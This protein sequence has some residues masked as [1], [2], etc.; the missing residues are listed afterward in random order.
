MLDKIIS[1]LLLST[2]VTGSPNSFC[3]ECKAV[4][5]AFDGEDPSTI[6]DEIC[7]LIGWETLC[8]DVMPTIVEW[9]QSEMT[10][11]VAC[12]ELCN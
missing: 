9:I 10:P 1:F 4:V 12:R 5:A 11:D 3:D 7:P 8:D 6:S 2:L